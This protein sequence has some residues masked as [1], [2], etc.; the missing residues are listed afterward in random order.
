MRII[1]FSISSLKQIYIQTTF[2]PE[3]RMYPEIRLQDFL[4]HT[5]VYY[6]ASQIHQHYSITYIVC[7]TVF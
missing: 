2:D 4:H 6:H 7:S 3:V 1:G 5:S